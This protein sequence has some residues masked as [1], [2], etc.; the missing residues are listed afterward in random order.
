[1]KLSF[2]ITVIMDSYMQYISLIYL[3]KNL[4]PRLQF[5]QFI[6]IN[7]NVLQKNISQIINEKDKILIKARFEQP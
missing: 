4:S 5:L 1:M 2:Y 3:N 6:F 7:N